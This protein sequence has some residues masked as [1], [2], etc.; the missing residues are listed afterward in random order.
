[1][2]SALGLKV[3]C[4]DTRSEGGA[5]H[6]TWAF[7]NSKREVLN[8]LI[9]TISGPLWD[10]H[11]QFGWSAIVVLEDERRQ[12]S[13]RSWYLVPPEGKLG[14]ERA[15][16]LGRTRFCEWAQKFQPA[17]CLAKAA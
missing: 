15:K 10:V 3:L 16:L 8:N 2:A 6:I 14:R 9:L 4:R 7:Q 11:G 1:M 5:V 12:A 13:Y 17:V